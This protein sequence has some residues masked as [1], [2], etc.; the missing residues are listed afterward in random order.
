M[1][2]HRF[3]TSTNAII[4]SRSKIL[5]LRLMVVMAGGIQHLG[6]IPQMII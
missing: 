6:F 5:L 2:V 3:I 4:T 1:E